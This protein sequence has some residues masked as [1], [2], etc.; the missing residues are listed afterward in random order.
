MKF[1][2]GFVSNSSSSSFCIYGVFID[3]QKF[4][5]AL[6]EKGFATKEEIPEGNLYDYADNWSYN[7]KKRNGELTEEEKITHEKIFF[8]DGFEYHCPYDFGD[9]YIGISWNEIGD[10]ETGSQFKAKIEEKIKNL[11]GE[12]IECGTQAEAWRDD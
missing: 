4:I 2:Q 6:I 8:K 10:D 1:R 3:E 7:N 12:D 9:C 11:L 5:E